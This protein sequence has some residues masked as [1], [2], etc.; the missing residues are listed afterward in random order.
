MKSARPCQDDTC[1]RLST[2]VDE[3]GIT[4][5]PGSTGQENGRRPRLPISAK[6]L[7]DQVSE[8]LIGNHRRA[9][10]FE[11]NAI[12]CKLGLTRQGKS[13][14]SCVIVLTLGRLCTRQQITQRGNQSSRRRPFLF[15]NSFFSTT[16]H[17][18][19]ARYQNQALASDQTAQDMQ[20]FLSIYLLFQTLL[21]PPST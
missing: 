16:Y 1:M 20:T 2:L 7:L 6:T 5:G 12:L 19:L 14:L 8:K 15:S 18:P 4:A 17:G 21:Q 11:C 3:R 10:V 9:R 13:Y